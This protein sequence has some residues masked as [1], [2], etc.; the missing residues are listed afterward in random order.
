MGE[1]KAAPGSKQVL[2]VG[3]GPYDP[4]NLHEMFRGPQW[5]EVRL[6]LNPEVEPDVVA[7]ITD[8]AIVEGDSMDGIW[9]AHNLEHLYPHE[10]TLAL[11]EF[12]R[13]LKPGGI[14]L[15]TVPDFQ[16]A[17]RLIAEGKAEEPAYQSPAGPITPLDMTFG[18]AAY[19][20]QGNLFMAHH[21]GF[22][23]QS[24]TNHLARAGFRKGKVMRKEAE[25]ALWAIAQKP[26]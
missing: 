11:K 2:H 13:V 14:L 19:I 3:C 25:F 9:S 22:T 6:D 5:R 20:Q 7:S 24:L 10:V 21:I 16:S 15:L 1:E 26:E 17:A 23:E 18:L 8:M 4:N 12:Y